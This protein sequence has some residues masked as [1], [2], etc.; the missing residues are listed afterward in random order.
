[1]GEAFQSVLVGS[2]RSSVTVETMMLIEKVAE[3]LL[4]CGLGVGVGLNLAP[5]AQ[6]LHIST[7]VE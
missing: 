6:S 5:R 2:L 7:V 3:E 1:M 4:G